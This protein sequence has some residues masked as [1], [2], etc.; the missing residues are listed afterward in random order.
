MFPKIISG[1]ELFAPFGRSSLSGAY[2]RVYLAK[3]NDF[4]QICSA[5]AP[6]T[7]DILKTLYEI[8]AGLNRQTV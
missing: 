2:N 6:Q 5:I 3:A 8:E 7:S 4:A 1:A